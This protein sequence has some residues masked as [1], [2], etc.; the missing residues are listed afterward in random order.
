[1]SL[2]LT[3]E[4]VSL[5]FNRLVQTDDGILYYDGLG[6]LLNIGGA[7]GYSGYSGIS[8]FSGKSGYS[9]YSGTSGSG[10]SGYSGA[11]QSGFSGFSGT[12]GINAIGGESGFSG[13]SGYSGFSGTSGYS[14]T[15]GES[16]YS[17][18]SGYSGIGTSGSSG[19]SGGGSSVLNN[20][21]AVVDPTVT[22]D[23]TAGYQAGITASL[24]FNTVRGVTFK[25]TDSSTGVAV[26]QED[27]QIG[28][29][30]IIAGIGGTVNTISILVVIPMS[31]IV[32]LGT[33][34]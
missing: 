26:W 7:S 2:D 13:T 11:G 15:S 24:W 31:A 33:K 28:T 16:G 22:D 1:M 8:G 17:G 32:N 10:V 20:M 27:F 21:N 4:K 6:N 12:S 19:Y 14:G 3:N 18:T 34:I 9:G 23:N 29:E 25:C 30:K 5:T